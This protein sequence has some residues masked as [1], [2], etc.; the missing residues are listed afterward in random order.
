MAKVFSI[1]CSVHVQSQEDAVRAMEALQKPMTGLALEGFS[2][3]LN[4]ATFDDDDEP[5]NPGNDYIERI[6]PNE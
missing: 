3:S 2:V 4:V 1:T 6:N 5:E